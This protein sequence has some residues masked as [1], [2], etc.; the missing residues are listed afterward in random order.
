LSIPYDYKFDELKQAFVFHTYNDVT[1]EIEINQ[2]GETYFPESLLLHQICYEISLNYCDSLKTKQD[3]RICLTVIRIVKSLL[4][5]GYILLFICDSLD[6][7]QKGRHRLF[8][9]WFTQYGEM[10][11]KHDIEV[12]ADNAL[13][14]LSWMINPKQHDILLIQNIF[15]DSINEHI[16]CK[17][18]T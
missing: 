15:Q 18:N 5:K 11:E 12:K 3:E 2:V 7:K 13:Y 16:V 1:Y 8:N 17:N 4:L 9:Q 6:K 10:F 14:Y